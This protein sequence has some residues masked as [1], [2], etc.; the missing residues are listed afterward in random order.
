L[1]PS[2][3][4]GL[5]PRTLTREQ[6]ADLRAAATLALY[7]CCEDCRAVLREQLQDEERLEAD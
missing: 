4:G 6:R 5:D 1:N 7:R 3:D 2:P